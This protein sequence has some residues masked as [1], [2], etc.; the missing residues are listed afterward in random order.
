MR[1][2]AQPRAPR[3]P[4]AALTLA[5]LARPACLVLVLPQVYLQ[6]SGLGNT[7]NPLL[8]LCD[9]KVYSMPMLLLVGWRG[10]PGHRDEP[11]HQVQG[12][13][14][15]A[16][17]SAMNVNYEVLPD[18]Q[19][20]MEK[21][22]D[23][24]MHYVKT[25]KA[26]YALLVRKNTFVPT[27]LEQM[28]NRFEVSREQAIEL[29][30]NQ[31]GKFD[32]CVGTTG[33]TSRELYELRAKRGEGH[34]RDFLCVGSMGHASNIA[35]GIAMGK[36]SRNVYCFDGDGAMLMHMGGV[37]TVG[38]ISPPNL[39]HIVF[40]NEAHESVGGQA[41]GAETLNLTG[42]AESCGYRKTFRATSPEEIVAA[43]KELAATEGPALL[44]IMV[45][46]GARSDLGRPK[47]SPVEN[48]QAFM[49]FL[50]A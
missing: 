14:T 3:T 18:Y 37:A 39:K 41:T 15:P 44:E 23:T 22:L 29:V 4:A 31:L 42:I 25:R 13:I 17:L 21:T 16:M 45:N 38:I 19:E 12:A 32:V 24:A 46:K 36:P 26:P 6:N 7:V 30:L 34:E 48:K 11:Q 8:S 50:D 1:G 33:F 20:G 40:N 43:T 27:K 49:N 35:L 9:S 47:S 10:E 5:A 2:A 28:P